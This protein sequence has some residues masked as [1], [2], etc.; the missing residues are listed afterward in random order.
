MRK[1]VDWKHRAHGVGYNVATSHGPKK[2]SVAHG[3]GRA[4][5][6]ISFRIGWPV[7]EGSGSQEEASA[8]TGPNGFN[9]L[10]FRQL[11]SQLPPPH[12]MALLSGVFGGNPGGLG[13]PRPQLAEGKKDGKKETVQESL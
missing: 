13:F 5:G 2:G 12:L 7:A 3:K 4:A 1:L 11:P 9:P 10:F 6:K 8:G